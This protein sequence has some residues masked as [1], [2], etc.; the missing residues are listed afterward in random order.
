MDFFPFKF[1]Q[2]SKFAGIMPKFGL[3]GM[4]PMCHQQADSPHEFK[5]Y[6][7]CKICNEGWGNV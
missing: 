6:K 4:K 1:I 3:P 7:L 2:G 5:L